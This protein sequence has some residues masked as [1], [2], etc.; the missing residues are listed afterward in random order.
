MFTA[1][2]RCSPRAAATEALMRPRGV[3]SISRS[4]LVSIETETPIAKPIWAYTTIAF[5][6]NRRNTSARIDSR[7]R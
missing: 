6:A 5:A 2:S 4:V 7:P 3:V 1:S